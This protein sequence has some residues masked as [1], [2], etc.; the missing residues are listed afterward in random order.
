M[1]GRLLCCKSLIKNALSFPGL[2]SGLGSLSLLSLPPSLLDRDFLGDLSFKSFIGFIG[3]KADDALRQRRTYGCKCGCLSSSAAVGLFS[4][5]FLSMLL[6]I[7]FSAEEYAIGRGE[8][9]D[10]FILFISPA[11]SGA[12]N[13]G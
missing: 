5:F 1:T 6:I 12:L 3:R 4:G 8:I 13:A 7:C 9:K 11:M 2:F 10:L